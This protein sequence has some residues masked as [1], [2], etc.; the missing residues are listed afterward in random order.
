MEGSIEGLVAGLVEGLVVEQRVYYRAG[1]A[2][3]GKL[4]PCLTSGPRVHFIEGPASP[5]FGRHGRRRLVPS[6]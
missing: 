2:G 6:R 3:G 5:S 4:N 1:F